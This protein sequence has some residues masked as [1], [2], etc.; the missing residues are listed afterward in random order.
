[1]KTPQFNKD[2]TLFLDRDGVINRRLMD[3]YVKTVGEFEFLPGVCEAIAIFSRIFGRI[4][5]VTNQRGIARGL[6]TED[7]LSA[8]HEIMLRGIKDAGG[9]IDGVFYCPHDVDDGCD[10]RKPKTGL[11]LRAKKDFCEID[12][13]KCVMVG[14]TASDVEFGR[15][16]GAY[17]VTVGSGVLGADLNTDSLMDFA[18]IL[19]RKNGL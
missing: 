9:R 2:W 11:A 13:D 10:C 17:V 1:M 6:M 14:D 8:V 15:G 18:N 5:V 3:D 4:V 7:D 19:K 12:F 16:I